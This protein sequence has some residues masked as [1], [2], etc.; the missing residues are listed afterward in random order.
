MPS[1]EVHEFKIESLEKRI[2]ELAE[3][4]ET[5]H[6][7]EMSAI[8]E[9]H[10]RIDD[11]TKIMMQMSE[12]NKD[13]QSVTAHQKA[14]DAEQKAINGRLNALERVTDSNTDTA[15]VI[16]RLGWAIMIGFGALIGTE[17]WQMMI[18]KGI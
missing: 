17:M 10:K 18:D 14:L 9:V 4:C 16:K 3:D 13:V 7:E 15:N 6:K 8:R 2:V 12:I 5:K 1:P 11:F